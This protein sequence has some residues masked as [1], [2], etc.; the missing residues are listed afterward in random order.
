MRL[1]PKPIMEYTITGSSLPTGAVFGLTS[2]GTNPDAYLVID[3]REGKA[4]QLEWHYGAARMTICKIEL[5]HKDNVVWTQQWVR[6]VPTAF[7]TWTFYYA[8]K[9]SK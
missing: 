6:P 5:R 7:D 3:L 8:P 9:L 4:G 1:L 2:N